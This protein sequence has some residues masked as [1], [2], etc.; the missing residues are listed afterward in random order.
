MSTTTCWE[1]I[2]E[3]YYECMKYS[4]GD[5]K[6]GERNYKNQVVREFKGSSVVAQWGNKKIY[7]VCDVEFNL[8][9][10]DASFEDKKSGQKIILADYFSRIYG[11]KIKHDKQPLFVVKSSGSDIYLPPEFCSIDGVPESIK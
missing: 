1:R 2:E 6:L 11:L 3:I 4:K 8:S 5:Y 10:F 7:I 9:P